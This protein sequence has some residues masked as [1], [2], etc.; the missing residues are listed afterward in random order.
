M[1][2]VLPLG[3]LLAAATLL[4]VIARL[5]QAYRQL[6][7]LADT[8]REARTDELTGLPNRRLFY[9]AL[10]GCL[11]DD[12]APDLAVLMIDLDRFK[13]INDS[14]GHRVGD[15]VLRQLGPRLQAV[16]GE[17]GTVARLGGDEFGLLLWPLTR[18]D[19]AT[20][21]AEQVCNVLRKPFRL[22]GMTL[23]V[24]A[25]IGIAVAPEHGRAGDILLQRADVAMYDAKRGH[26]RW[27][28]YSAEHDVYTRD[29]LELMEDLRDAFDAEQFVL[30][31]QPKVNLATGTVTAVEALVRWQHPTRG[32][33]AP[34]RFLDLAEQSGLMG[35]LAMVVLDQALAQQMAWAADGL[36]LGMA[37][38]L[39]AANMLDPDLVANVARSLSRHGVQPARVVLEITEDTL[40]VDSAE[41]N[42]VLH[43]LRG[44]GV[45][46]SV[47]DYGTGFSSLAYLRHLPVNEIKLDRSFLEGAPEDERAVAIIRSTVDLAHSLGL[48]M[49]AEGIESSDALAMV[50]GLGCDE[51]QGFLWGRPV[52]AHELSFAL[53]RRIPAAP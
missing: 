2:H 7:A 47:D 49:V 23:R 6:R 12:D 28:L 46:L 20:D 14:L 3:T 15:E 37:V 32:L 11:G 30:H 42:Q 1:E 27:S 44:L 36:D 13:E 33:L 41:A 50:T 24:D 22:E 18:P 10:N 21:L 34:D 39:S 9:E 53:A 17:A 16:V 8:R 31:Y 26:H 48:R 38:N 51:A 52:P 5:G 4:V 29:R 43:E 19:D 35:T 45:G 25:S 40:M